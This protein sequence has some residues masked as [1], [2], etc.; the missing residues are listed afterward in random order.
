MNRQCVT[1]VHVEAIASFVHEQRL[2]DDYCSK[3]V[4]ENQ[5][6]A[7]YNDKHKHF[8]HNTKVYDRNVD[9]RDRSDYH[10]DSRSKYAE[11]S[12][13]CEPSV[14]R[15]N[16]TRKVK[17]FRDVACDNYRSERSSRNKDFR[18]E[19]HYRY[20]N[21]SKVC[22]ELDFRSRSGHSSATVA[23]NYYGGDEAYTSKGNYETDAVFS[24][25]YNYE[26]DNQV[27][28]F[29]NATNKTLFYSIKLDEE[30]SE[31]R[32]NR[33]VFSYTSNVN[34]RSYQPVN[35]SNN[36]ANLSPVSSTSSALTPN[37]YFSDCNSERSAAQTS[38]NDDL[39]GVND[40]DLRFERQ[41]KEIVTEIRCQYQS[42]GCQIIAKLDTITNHEKECAF[43]PRNSKTVCKVCK[44]I[45]NLEHDCLNELREEL[46][47]VSRRTEWFKHS[48]ASQAH[49]PEEGANCVWV[50]FYGDKE[51][52]V[53]KF[54]VTNTDDTRTVI[55]RSLQHLGLTS[56]QGD[57]GF[58]DTTYQLVFASFHVLS[59][60]ES[61]N[62][63]TTHFPHDTHLILIPK[64]I[65]IK[66]TA[67]KLYCDNEHVMV[68]VPKSVPFEID[69]TIT[70]RELKQIIATK[71][72]VDWNRHT[73]EYCGR[74]LIDSM[75]LYVIGLSR[76][77]K[78]DII[79]I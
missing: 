2:I 22:T 45:V 13:I 54:K 16:E 49:N 17:E 19:K 43:N 72:P 63:F 5:M 4:P 33:E 8:Y 73:L 1:D 69:P 10:F 55:K 70:A 21:K 42:L 11:D 15:K 27:S 68:S 7:R 23:R 31:A 44:L 79:A 48:N 66:V 71:I 60:H 35:S 26:N 67:R 9:R 50:H 32:D 76:N 25:E 14:D 36:N 20:P 74:Q 64:V 18:R 53:A 58:E 57:D 52:K 38:L 37:L 28:N 6:A 34:S 65:H 24:R 40:V 30:A 12:R 75:I 78:V 41:N 59:A 51:E 3:R 46:N 77:D 62:S 56:Q 47:S 29:E 61:L 39:F